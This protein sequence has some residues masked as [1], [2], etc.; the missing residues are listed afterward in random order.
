[1]APSKELLESGRKELE[2][3]GREEKG[4]GEGEIGLLTNLLDTNYLLSLPCISRVEKRDTPEGLRHLFYHHVASILG[5]RERVVEG[6][7]EGIPALLYSIVREIWLSTEH[8]DNKKRKRMHI[9][10]KKPKCRK[11]TS[12]EDASDEEQV[13]RQQTCKVRGGA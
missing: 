5:W 11:S 10:R 7:K 12:G 13:Q 3:W 4:L 9:H 1:M 2:R 6:D 8:G